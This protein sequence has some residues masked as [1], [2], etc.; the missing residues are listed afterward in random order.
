MQKA[1]S[2]LAKIALCAVVF[3][4]TGCSLAGPVLQG[5]T[6]YNKMASDYSDQVLVASVLR[7]RDSLPIDMTN[8]STIT[9][10]MSV[11]GTL[12]LTVPF[13]NG[14]G[15]RNSAGPTVMGTS[16]PT[17]NMAPLN[18]QGFTLGMLQPVSPTY[19]A[20]KWDD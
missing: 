14:P 1:T 13:G 18:T 16:S 10:S 3:S 4:M 2:F 7:A 6:D 19:L 9:G 20:S 8:L 5:A 11:Q 17:W 12:G 15:S